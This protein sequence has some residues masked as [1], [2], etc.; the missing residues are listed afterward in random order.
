MNEYHANP[1]LR[2]LTSCICL[3][4][5]AA[6]SLYP[7][8]ASAQVHAAPPKG[9]RIMILS[10]EGAL[11]NIEARTARE[12]I[13]QVQDENHKPVAG[14]AVLFTIHSGSKGAGGSFQNNST[15]Y[16]TVTN[17][18]GIATASGFHPN[19][20]EGSYQI[21]VSANFGPLTASSVIN[22]INMKLAPTQQSVNTQPTPQPPA[23]SGIGHVLHPHLSWIFTK[24]AVIIGGVVVVGTVIGVIVATHPTSPTQITP[25]STTVGAPAA[26]HA[27]GITFHF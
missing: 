23:V 1:V 12:P 2:K 13:V 10:G 24:P 3:L 17:A 22:E 26:R 4:L 16:S 6:L 9:L 8:P 15:T 5:I 11:N 18:N 14:A 25:G 20:T 7:I 21:S 19:Q 27:P